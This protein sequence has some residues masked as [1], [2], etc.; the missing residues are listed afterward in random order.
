MDTKLAILKENFQ[1]RLNQ[2]R[3]KIK[4]LESQTTN[5]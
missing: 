1:T 2:I 4:E 3:E 5:K